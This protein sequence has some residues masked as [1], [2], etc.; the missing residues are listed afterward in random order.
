[1]IILLGLLIVAI[2]TTIYKETNGCPPLVLIRQCVFVDNSIICGGHSD[3]D[4]VNIF[5]TLEKNL[6][7]SE[8]HFKSFKLHAVPK[9]SGISSLYL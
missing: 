7:E 8:K 5:Q 1:M 9:N 3:I 6:T 4:L 2:L